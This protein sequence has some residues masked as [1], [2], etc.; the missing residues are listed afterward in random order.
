M[1]YTHSI[2]VIQIDKLPLAGIA[3]YLIRFP[4]LARISIYSATNHDPF[5]AVRWTHAPCGVRPYIA[6]GP[7]S[8]AEDIRRFINDAGRIVALL[9]ENWERPIFHTER[10]V[11]SRA[12]GDE[13]LLAI[14]AADKDS[15]RIGTLHVEIDWTAKDRRYQLS[16]LDTT[17]ANLP[18]AEKLIIGGGHVDCQRPPESITD[19]ICLST[20]FQI[21]PLS[22]EINDIFWSPGYSLSLGHVVSIIGSANHLGTLT[23]NFNLAWP[24]STD[25]ERFFRHWPPRPPRGRIGY[26]NITFSFERPG[27][28]LD[29]AEQSKLQ[30]KDAEWIGRLAELCVVTMGAHGHYAAIT[31]DFVLKNNGKY[32][33]PIA[34]D[35]VAMYFHKAV[36]RCKEAHIAAQR[37]GWWRIE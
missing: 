25:I 19:R 6:L 11:L 18:Q 23:L 20:Y 17:I 5:A 34:N 2:R 8:T 3:P 26:T 4:N 9:P 13:E 16:Q 35:D 24:T 28:Q 36:K 30:S 31:Y 21:N 1:T 7:H 33:S 14:L 32:V 27:R 37:P 15:H 12:F 29:I 10:V 22:R